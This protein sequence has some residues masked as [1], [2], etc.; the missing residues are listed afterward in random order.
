MRI[1]WGSRSFRGLST[2]PTPCVSKSLTA[3]T[4]SSP[5]TQ[6][7]CAVRWPTSVCHCRRHSTAIR[8]SCRLADHAVGKDGG[9]TVELIDAVSASTVVGAGG[10]P[11]DFWAQ[12][13][14]SGGDEGG[15]S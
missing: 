15:H 8:A 7:C 11:H 5:T 4:A 9:H 14:G 6:R 3:S 10:A 13:P 12:Q 1:L 2:T